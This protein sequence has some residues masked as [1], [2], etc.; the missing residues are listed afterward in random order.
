M[1]PP[2]PWSSELLFDPHLGTAPLAY[3]APQA[4]VCSND[5]VRFLQR[6]GSGVFGEV[7]K[8]EYKGELV[9][10]KTTGCPT[11][12][13]AEELALLQRAQGNHAVQLLGVEEGTSKGTT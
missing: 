8:A 7:W 2:S 11:G 4:S 3:S 1:R 9:A 10:A 5:S 6:L 12:F 13:R